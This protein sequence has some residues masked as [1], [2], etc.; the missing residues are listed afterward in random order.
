MAVDRVGCALAHRGL[1]RDTGTFAGTMLPP[2]P[3]RHITATGDCFALTSMRRNGTK[4]RGKMQ[5]VLDEVMRAL[6]PDTID[7]MAGKIGASPGQTQNAIQAA[8]PVLLG[9]MSRNAATPGGAE[10]LHR[11]AV[12]DHSAN[13]PM[14][15]IGSLLGGGAGG[16]AGGG[17][18]G[19]L[20]GVLGG[21]LGGGGGAGQAAGGA[22]N[23][24]SDGLG[25][26]G[27]VLGGAQQRAAGGVG[28]AGGIDAGSAMQLMA[29][30]A[31]IVMAALGR[32]AQRGGLDA[33]G[34]A[35][36][37]GGDMQRLGGGAPAGRDPVSA[38]L[39]A[40]GDGDVDAAD[41]MARGAGLLGMLGKR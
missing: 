11:A 34:L 25:I 30:L 3:M 7:Q 28:R 1:R 35:G 36:A 38:L 21:L 33:Q 37:L 4:W 13:D 8:L 20:L 14:A 27:H 29:M 41:L 39:D 40:D 6:G 22:R 19:Q 10:A 9:A 32:N 5:G 17:G 23:P 16:G 15:L 12:R 18:A 26:L 31:P 24:M 2:D